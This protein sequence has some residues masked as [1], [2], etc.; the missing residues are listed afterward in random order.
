MPLFHL[1]EFN[2]YFSTEE[3]KMNTMHSWLYISQVQVYWPHPRTW[4]VLVGVSSSTKS[5]TFSRWIKQ[6]CYQLQHTINKSVCTPLPHRRVISANNFHISPY[7]L[8][9]HAFPVTQLL[10]AYCAIINFEI[11]I[12][13]KFTHED[14][15]F[16]Y[17]Q[18]LLNYL[19]FIFRKNIIH[20]FVQLTWY[21]HI[22]VHGYRPYLLY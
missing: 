1:P 9:K 16:I 13:M 17:F 22:Q 20:N 7:N 21:E 18:F 5:Y 3:V 8:K 10:S 12:V 6:W 19:Y 4:Y 11:S 14:V 2:V 15:F